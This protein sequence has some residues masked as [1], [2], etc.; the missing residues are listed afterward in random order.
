[1]GSLRIGALAIGVGLDVLGSF[2]VS[3]AA[4]IAADI[5]FGTLAPVAIAALGFAQTTYGAFV[6]GCI[7]KTDYAAYGLAVAVIGLVIALV[8]GAKPV[9]DMP[10]WFNSICSLGALPAGALGG[11]LAAG[12]RRL[13]QA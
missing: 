5:D 11:Y 13:D 12:L 4:S 6:A 2:G 9:A 7:A 10:A 8:L 1:M 3:L